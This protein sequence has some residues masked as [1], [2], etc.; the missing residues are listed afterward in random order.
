VKPISTGLR[1]CLLVTSCVVSCLTE[2]QTSGGG[3]LTGDWIATFG[4]ST[5]AGTLALHMAQDA[6]GHVSGTYTSTLGGAGLVTGTVSEGTLSATLAQTQSQCPGSYQ[7][8]LTLSADGG[9]GTFSGK[10]CLGDHENGVVSMRR[11]TADETTPVSITRDKDGNIQPFKLV[12]Q[13]GLPFWLSRSGSAF[14]AVGA[15]EVGGYFRLLVLVSNASE[16]DFNFIPSAIRVDDLNENKGLSYVS[17][18]E[19]AARIEHRMAVAAALMAFGNG[20]RAYSQSMVTAHTTGTLSAY[21]SN[22]TWVRGSYFA[23]TTTRVPVDH[24]QLAA[25]NSQNRAVLAARAGQRI[26]ELNR[27]AMGSQTILPKGYVLGTTM[28]RKPKTANLKGIVGKDYKSYFVRVLVPIG[29]EKFIFL[30]P[31]ELLQA[32][33]HPQR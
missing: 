28:F 26:E 25:E 15:Q 30:F 31:V 32:L 29:D 23:T 33:P 7:A 4:D 17:P 19:I 24:T 14:L 5:S 9:D 11:K 2:A 8:K 21:D 10:D 6:A 18:S 1:L 20:M 13:N 3:N 12:Y 16:Q 22:G 27:G